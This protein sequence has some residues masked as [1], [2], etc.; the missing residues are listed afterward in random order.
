TGLMQVDPTNGDAVRTMFRL[1][2]NK[3]YM[4]KQRS[5]SVTNDDGQNE[6]SGWT[7]NS[8]SDGSGKP[9]GVGTPSVNG[10]CVAEGAWAIIASHDG[11]YIFDGGVPVKIS[12]EIQTDWDK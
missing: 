12:Q 9:A 11:A 2:D 10:V 4:V 7:I 5:M 6:P 3:L 8:E 1:L